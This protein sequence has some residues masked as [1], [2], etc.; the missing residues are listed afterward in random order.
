M[1]TLFV[2]LLG[3]ILLSS[4]GK[5]D[6]SEERVVILDMGDYE[7]GSVFKDGGMRFQHKIR[8]IDKKVVDYQWFSHRY[9]PGDTVMVKFN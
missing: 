8:R 4:C 9:E 7:P 1:K 2:I 3:L 6:S 5:R